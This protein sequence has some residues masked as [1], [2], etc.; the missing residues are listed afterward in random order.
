MTFSALSF[1]GGVNSTAMLLH[2]WDAGIA[3]GIVLFADT[4]GEQEGTYKHVTQMALW[5]SARSIPFVKVNNG[6]PEKGAT[7]EENCLRRRE[8]PSLAYGFKG[9]SVKWKRQPMDRYLRDHVPEVRAAW[10]AGELV[11]RFIG[12]DAGEVRRK[13]LPP[14]DRFVYRYPL[15]EAGID[16]EGCIKL[17]HKHGIEPPP[18]SSCFF[19]PAMKKHEILALPKDLQERAKA[20]EANAAPNLHTVRGLGRSWSWTDFLQGQAAPNIE[21]PPP[22]D[23]TDEDE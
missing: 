14:D 21:N 4:G 16:R 13:K 18:K 5:C 10:A 20:M 6:S 8:L 22:C 15:V 2:L 19:C 11:T 3:P 9:C 1:G 17:I 7:L 23:C 12:I